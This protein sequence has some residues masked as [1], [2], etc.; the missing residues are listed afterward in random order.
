MGSH[1]RQWLRHSLVYI[2]LDLGGGASKGSTKVQRD[3]R[4]D[5]Q[6]TWGWEHRLRCWKSLLC[7]FPVT[8]TAS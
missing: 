3:S 1:W 2:V 7:V 5:V 6:S 8:V 4:C